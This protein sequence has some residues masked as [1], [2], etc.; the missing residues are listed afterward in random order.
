MRISL[1]T[2]AGLAD[3]E[4]DG[5][6]TWKLKGDAR[7]VA[8]EWAIVG[9]R[10]VRAEDPER[11]IPVDPSPKCI[12]S[13]AT[14][15]AVGTACARLFVVDEA[16][17]TVAPVDSFDDI[18]T[19]DGWYTP[20]GGPPD[21]RSLAVDASGT[22]FVNVHVGGVWRSDGSG[23][24]EVVERDADTHQVLAMD[25][26][27][28]IAAAVGFGQ[29]DDGGHSFRW[30]AG[31]LHATYC[32]AVAVADG[33]ALVTASGGPRSRQGAVYR[34]PVDA[35]DRAFVKCQDG[36]PEWFEG[37]IDTFQLAAL[38]STVALASP[39]GTVFLSDDA[40]ASWDRL[41]DGL[42]DIRALTLA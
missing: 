23:W 41:T 29:S 36:L 13:T 32:R 4:T 15:A 37:N 28:A 22:V 9:D 31:G 21:T 2:S 35:H 33:F 12:A 14:G 10:V 34:R 26:T 6:L 18:P 20:W 1:A 16:A 17:M 39:D 19:R 42:R 27:V 38:G 8:G 5:H 40:G 7:A 11:S 30:T 3:L 24:T 25:G